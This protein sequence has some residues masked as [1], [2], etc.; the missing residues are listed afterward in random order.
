MAIEKLGT[1][2]ESIGTTR[3]ES[4]IARIHTLAEQ[5]LERALLDQTP[6]SMFR[7]PSSA[8]QA[9]VEH[10]VHRI[11]EQAHRFELRAEEMIIGIKQAWA[12]LAPIRARQLGDRDADVLREVVSRSIEVFHETRDASPHR[13]QV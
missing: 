3:D 1:R 5:E 9:A 13:F 6:P 12:Q 7:H 4:R 2:H 11:C 10:A 8:E